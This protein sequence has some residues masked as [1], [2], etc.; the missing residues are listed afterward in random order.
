MVCLVLLKSVGFGRYGRFR[1]LGLHGR[2]DLIAFFILGF[3]GDIPPPFSNVLNT[4][5]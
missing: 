1:V 3:G 2:F 4:M 5:V